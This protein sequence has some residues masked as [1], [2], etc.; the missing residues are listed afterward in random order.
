M[1]EVRTAIIE[2]DY[3]FLPSFIKIEETCIQKNQLLGTTGKPDCS[4]SGHGNQNDS[5]AGEGGDGTKC[6]IETFCARNEELH[7][8]RKSRDANQN[9]RKCRQLVLEY[10]QHESGNLQDAAYDAQ[11]VELYL[12]GSHLKDLSVVSEARLKFK[13]HNTLNMHFVNKK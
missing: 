10:N 8:G 3:C 6:R 1:Q 4:H 12:V 2:S 11:R 5:E 13:L 7:D 9:R